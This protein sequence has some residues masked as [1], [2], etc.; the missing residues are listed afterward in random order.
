[1]NKNKFFV[2]INRLRAVAVLLVL[3]DHFQSM[4]RYVVIQGRT[5]ADFWVGVDLFLV[6]SGFV[7]TS[8]FYNSYLKDGYNISTIYK[9]YYKRFYRI[10][11]AMLAVL[12]I[13]V[14]LYYLLKYFGYIDSWALDATSRLKGAASILS[15]TANLFYG[16]KDVLPPFDLGYFWS[17]SLEWQ[18]YCIFPLLIYFCLKSWRDRLITLGVLIVLMSIFRYSGIFSSG[19]LRY[20]GFIVGITIFFIDYSLRGK[21]NN[22]DRVSFIN[23]LYLLVLVWVLL[24]LPS[25]L[26]GTFLF[27]ILAVLSGCILYL[28]SLDVGYLSYGKYINIVLDY[29]GNRSYLIYLTHMTSFLIVRA[30]CYFVKF[31]ISVGGVK[32]TMFL[33]F[34]YIVIQVFIIEILAKYIEKPGIKKSHNLKL[35]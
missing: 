6:I 8:T 7:V 14:G 2:E 31:D 13:N 5:I 27:T 21:V 9:F 3:V 16:Q 29:I 20:D 35:N 17:V 18:F 11:P 19:L 32:K 34:L 33:L 30:A 12:A 28:C 24:V 26:S 15:F 1:M 23:K 25:V 22:I 10:V 4:V